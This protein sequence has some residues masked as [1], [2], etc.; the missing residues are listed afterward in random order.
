MP[1]NY[2]LNKANL[3]DLWVRNYATIL[4]VLILKSEFG[5]KNI[6]DFWETS[7]WTQMYFQLS[8][9]A[10]RS[11]NQ[12]ASASAGYFLGTFY[13]MKLFINLQPEN[14]EHCSL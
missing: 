2:Q 10:E 7:P 14:Q 5:P 1:W 11:D 9:L 4:Q 13:N 3:T 6:Q 8:L 12:H